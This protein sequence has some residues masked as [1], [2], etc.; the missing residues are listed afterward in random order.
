M[1]KPPVL[2]EIYTG[3]KN[4]DEW[5]D[6]FESVAA[7][8]GWDEAA[9][10]QWL[11]V[12]LT[13]R[14]SSA[15]R[16]LSADTRASYGD[17][18]KALRE[19]FEPDSKKELYMA[20]LNARSRKRNEDWPVY[21]ED[22]KLLA[23]KAY[24]G[25]QEEAREQFALNQY[26]AQLDNPQVAFGVRQAKPKTINDAVRLTL[27]METYLRSPRLTKVPSV[28]ED[29]YE[30]RVVAAASAV[31]KSAS[32]NT[33]QLLLERMERIET[34]LKSCKLSTCARE[35]PTGAARQRGRSRPLKCWNCNQEGHIS[36]NC[37]EPRSDSGPQRQGNGKPSEQ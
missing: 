16:R 23:D 12:R 14:A 20:T 6:H 3:E 30:P 26:L 34:E 9:K 2:P 7:V 25:L 19:R 15:F 32:D 4:W 10:L 36:R 37:Q 11:R 8:C 21:G 28:G 27:E 13:G 22:L 24:P 5:I 17:A 35:Q 18:V 31:T 29:Q 1:S 33:L